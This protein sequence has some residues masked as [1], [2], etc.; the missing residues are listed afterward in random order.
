[1][2]GESLGVFTGRRRW[3]NVYAAAIVVVF[4]VLAIVAAVRFFGTDVTNARILWATAFLFSALVVMS[5]KA[6]FW[7]QMTRNAV[8]R[9]VKRVELRLVERG[10][11]PRNE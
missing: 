1:M 9:E 10:P 8:L 5:L 2:I 11:A 7:M 3:W 4:T 6:W